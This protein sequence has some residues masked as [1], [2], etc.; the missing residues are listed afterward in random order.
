VNLGIPPE[1]LDTVGEPKLTIISGG[2][3]LKAIIAH[4]P[5]ALRERHCG[6]RRPCF[7]SS[8]RPRRPQTARFQRAHLGLRFPGFTGEALV[9]CK[10]LALPE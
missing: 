10:C 4:I 6:R 5:E 9:E 1:N 3:P 7:A 2:I 8:N